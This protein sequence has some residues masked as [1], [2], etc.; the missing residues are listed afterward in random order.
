MQ[1]LAF[2]IPEQTQQEVSQKAVH[3]L[4]TKGFIILQEMAA[5]FAGLLRVW[6]SVQ[7]VWVPAVP[8]LVRCP[9]LNIPISPD[10]GSTITS[11]QQG[12]AVTVSKLL[13]VTLLL[14]V[15]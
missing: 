1:Q 2:C 5:N 13:Y 4:N 11:I 3:K 8:S 9:G 12:A 7:P 15:I 10:S 14:S 6:S